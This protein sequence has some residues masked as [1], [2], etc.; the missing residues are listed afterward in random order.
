MSRL[1]SL[2][3]VRSLF[4]KNS[5]S[6]GLALILL[7]VATVVP[8]INLPR[9]TFDYIV[10]FDI[11]QSM[12]VEDYELDGAPASRLDYAR[13]AARTA[14][15]QLP[16]GSK[17][18]W[19]IFAEYRALLLL[20]PVEVCSNYNDLLASLDNIDGRMRW[21][22]ASEIAKGV[23]WSMRAAKDVE[24][25][26]SV[27]FITDGQEAPPLDP[28]NPPQMFDDLTPG[29]LSGWLMGAG[30]ETP[31]RIPRIDDNG[32]RVGY[33]KS[34]EV[35]QRYGGGTAEDPNAQPREHLSAIHESHLKQLAR[36]VGFGYTRLAGP[37]SISEAMR[38]SRL[39]RRTL[40]PTEVFWVPALLALILLSLRFSPALGAAP[41]T[42][43]ISSIPRP[44]E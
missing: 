33:W 41:N 7:I 16:C 18:G 21:A 22:N 34:Y 5:R 32:Q 14:L 19:G 6:I 3:N 29:E 2:N 12:G 10:I 27:L 37:A 20:S 39:A 9:N 8:P 15:R 11:S 26:P 23:Y 36:Q 28:D 44:L 30:G 31:R 38:D 25:K 17:V 4:D 43:Q 13:A 40:A 1:S 42:L 35:L 24:G